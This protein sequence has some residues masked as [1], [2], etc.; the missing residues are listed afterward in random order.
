MRQINLGVV[1]ALIALVSLVQAGEFNEVLNIGDP[2]PA[3]TDLPGTDGKKHSLADHKS[4]D[5]VV[6]V[7]T[8]ASCPTAVDYEDR[9]KELSKRFGGEKGKVAVVAVCV[10]RV[11]GDTLEDLTERAAKREFAFEYLYD[12]SQKIARDYGAIFTPEFY[13]LNQDRKVIYMGALDD[14]TDASKV[15]K[16]FVEEA[17]AAATK[18]EAPAVKETIARGCRVRYARERK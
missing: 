12:E 10:N 5:F 9:I 13:V 17:I 1:L 14:V 7:F 3:W 8:C 16:R 15:Q 2:A 6:L 18:G 11:K 4:K